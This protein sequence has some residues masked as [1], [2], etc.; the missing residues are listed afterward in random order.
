MRWWLYSFCCALCILR[1]SWLWAG[2]RLQAGWK[3]AGIVKWSEDSE[4]ELAELTQNQEIPFTFYQSH[5]RIC[6]CCCRLMPFPGKSFS[7]IPSISYQFLFSMAVVEVG[8]MASFDGGFKCASCWFHSSSV[9]WGWC[10]WGLG[11]E[12]LFCCCY[13]FSYISFILP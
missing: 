4:I 7:A 8:A 11:L 2:G 9:C 6:L 12:L 3:L 13:Y 10:R 5:E 1:L